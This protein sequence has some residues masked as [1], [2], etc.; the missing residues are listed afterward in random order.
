MRGA[1]SLI[2]P[3]NAV[4]Y[5]G[6]STFVYLV[7]KDYDQS[8]TESVDLGGF[9]KVPVATG[10][11]NG[12]YIVIT[13]NGLKA[14]DTLCMPSMETTAVYSASADTNT[15]LTMFGNMGG[16]MSN[17]PRGERPDGDPNNRDR[18]NSQG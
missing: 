9:S 12:T 5:E 13:G 14:G 1:V 7:P 8:Q 10:M 3:V 15:S 2:V 11:S 17:R 6:D 18:N 4:Q 16:S